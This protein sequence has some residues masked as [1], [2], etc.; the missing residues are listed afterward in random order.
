M[1]GL[2][3]II[4]LHGALGSSVQLEKLAELL[5]D[6]FNV[7]LLNFSGHGKNSNPPES[8]SID[9]LGQ[10]L[11]SFIEKHKILDPNIFGYSLGGYVGLYAATKSLVPFNSVITLGTKFDWSDKTYME[12]F[13]FVDSEVLLSKY[14]A[15]IES[16][17]HLHGD[18]W[19]SLVNYTKEFLIDLGNNPRL[20]PAELLKLQSKVLITRGDRD[21]TVFE[22]ESRRIADILPNGTYVEIPATPHIIERVD[23]TTLAAMIIEFLEITKH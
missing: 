18:N 4:L 19:S 8:I 20:D 1:T 16:L 21:K 13:S 14:P 17:V 5:N 7:F 10:E 11:T 3:N 9:K 6:K 12:Q 15:V 2:K 22:A 23:P